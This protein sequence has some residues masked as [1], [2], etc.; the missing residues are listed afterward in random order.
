MTD[1]EQEG[2]LVETGT[3]R[4]D[5]ARMK[6]VLSRYQLKRA[7]QFAAAW[8][9]CST[10]CSARELRLSL[11]EGPAGAGFELS[12]DGQPLAAADLEDLY[13]GLFA[14]GNTAG[15]FLAAGLLALQRTA[16]SSITVSSGGRAAEL[17][18]A[19]QR[20]ASPPADGGLTSLRVLW[21]HGAPGLPFP[22]VRDEFLRCLDLC[23]ASFTCSGDTVSGYGRQEAGRSGIYFSIGGRRG[24]VRRLDREIVTPDG[25]HP[26]QDSQVSLH[27]LGVKVEALAWRLPPVAVALDVNDDALDL[28]VTMAACVKNEKLDAVRLFAV[29]LVQDLLRAETGRQRAALADL[30]AALGDR[31]TL[32]LW[33]ARMKS[34]EAWTA[35]TTDWKDAWLPEFFR[36]FFEAA[37]VSPIVERLYDEGFRYWWLQDA[38]RR[39]LKGRETAPQTPWHRALWEAP[40][41]LSC[42]GKPLS[43]ADLHARRSGGRMT[44]SR[45]TAAEYPAAAKAVWLA[46]FRD[47]DFLN[48]WFPKTIWDWA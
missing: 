7:E 17:T 24:A 28:D 20:R 45:S 47:E 26:E 42:A 9:R 37:P 36:Q 32:R 12:F 19:G 33:R 38:C 34:E 25:Q 11:A 15:R 2:E 18:P 10:A 43:L 46:S 41:M 8:L 23:P 5:A 27:V 14:G 1:K 39:V 44:V 21:G 48:E 22:A 35:A 29:E 3:F 4:V 16:P 6:E 31:R 40:V 30:G 13:S